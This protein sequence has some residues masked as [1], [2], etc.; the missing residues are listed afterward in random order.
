MKA[1]LSFYI[2]FNQWKKSGTVKISELSRHSLKSLQRDKVSIVLL[3]D[4]MTESLNETKWSE[5]K[6]VMNL[7]MP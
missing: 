2:N 1:R 6:Y 5:L 7:D 4:G 3:Y